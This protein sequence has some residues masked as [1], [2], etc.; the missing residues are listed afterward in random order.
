M[1]SNSL[2][3]IGSEQAYLNLPS[4]EKLRHI[5]IGRYGGNTERGAHKNED[6]L[7]V[8]QSISW[9]FVTLIDAHHSCDS[10]ELII[11]TLKENEH[12]IKAILD[13]KIN[14]LFDQIE[15]LLLQIFKSDR[16]K[17][18]CR[19]LK[20]EASCLICIRK[21]NVLWWFSVGDCQLLLIH[22]DL[23]KWGQVSLNQRNFYE[24]MG[25]VNTF[26][27]T[28]PSYSLGRRE[29]RTGVNCILLITDGYLE[30]K[31]AAISI[32]ELC[33]SESL[34]VSFLNNLHCQQT[35]DS[36]TLVRWAVKNELDAAMPSDL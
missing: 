3:W 1:K 19:S 2:N 18:K 8:W 9:E 20:G 29:L 25:K 5:T 6:G 36:T 28:V 17:N 13:S 11:A 27:K 12:S 31:E 26:E 14:V 22:D 23:E 35:V 24:W 7:L 32:S 16:F 21:E 30:A 10:A 15:K 34:V 33:R 4:V